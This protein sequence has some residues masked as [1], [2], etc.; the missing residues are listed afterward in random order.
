MLSNII[1]GGGNAAQYSG[2][3]MSSGS[4][5][6]VIRAGSVTNDVSN[7]GGGTNRRMTAADWTAFDNNFSR[8]GDL[9]PTISRS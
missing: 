5:A 4:S 3:L 7:E 6:V 8:F 2:I 9:I 1:N